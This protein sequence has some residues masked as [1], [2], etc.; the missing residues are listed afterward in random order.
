MP[1]FHY[2][3]YR[4]PYT[5]TLANL[6]GSSERAR[7]QA[8]L[9]SG[10][11]SARMWSG[12]G[13]AISGTLN[14]LVRY[15]ADE[16]HRQLQ[17]Q[18]TTLRQQQIDKETGRLA[19]ER[20]LNDVVAGVGRTPVTAG[21]FDPGGTWN[22][23]D[24]PTAT[25]ATASREE[26]LSRLPANLRPVLLKQ[27]QS[28]D[29]DFARVQKSRLDLE[30]ARRKALDD[31][32]DHLGGLGYAVTQWGGDPLAVRGAIA[33]A[34][35]K[36]AGDEEML[37]SIASFESRI[38][39]GS[40]VK[41]NLQAASGLASQSQKYA[42]LMRKPEGKT[43][44]VQTVDDKGNLVVKIVKD[45]PGQTFP[46][47]QTVPTLGSKADYL[48]RYASKIGK[49]PK[50]L[51]ADDVAK[52][53]HLYALASHIAAENPDSLT[54]EKRAEIVA[55]I[56]QYPSI[57]NDL[58]PTW[59]GAL[60]A[61]L[62]RAGFTQ[63]EHTANAAT[64][65]TAEARRMTARTRVLADPILQEN[66]KKTADLLA[67]IEASYRVQVGQGRATTPQPA[68]KPAAPKTAATPQDLLK[69]AA[70]GKYTL[71]DHSVWIKGK[72]G[73]VRPATK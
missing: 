6:I 22:A 48:T 60:I 7:A 23:N 10:E 66:P 67:E 49:A 53:E 15:K 45:E 36:Y 71:T 12:I 43:R 61:D 30:A 38:G 62:G 68:P 28:S 17:A 25:G 9:A 55:Q 47:P 72:D 65:A 73:V 69:A 18:E 11:A 58:P 33:D 21:Q 63:F 35:E 41:A 46:A 2:E 5:A 31:V 64:K 16:P 32:T 40:D 51:T 34:K 56:M 50:L 26:L 57:Y 4:S 20:T 42:A 44:E 19:D 27:F 59:K 3:Q 13:Q 29:E 24:Q 52:G 8:A 37:K 54:V 14:D 70:P 1:M 39:D